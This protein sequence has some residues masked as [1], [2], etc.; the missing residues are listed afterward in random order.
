VNSSTGD[1]GFLSPG[2]AKQAWKIVALAALIFSAWSLYVVARHWGVPPGIAAV[3]SVTFDG[4]AVLA[5]DYSLRHIHAR[6]RGRKLARMSMFGFAAT[7]VY[8]NAQH[9]ALEHSPPAA[10]VLFAAPAVIALLLLEIHARFRQSFA[11]PRANAYPELPPIR[12]FSW[13]LHPADSWEQ[14][15]LS[16]QPQAV[17]PE[18]DPAGSGAPEL[19][20]VTPGPTR[21]LAIL[22]DPSAVRAWAR[23]QG[24]EVGAHGPIPAHVEEA[25]RQAMVSANGHGRTA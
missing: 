13:L 24:I 9:A 11:R 8:L 22:G 16:V 2:L 3:T 12:M 14:F 5:A 6:T 19:F 1:R 17:R 18:L 10:A 23:G 7:S 21:D 20:T 25:W 4:G 15:K